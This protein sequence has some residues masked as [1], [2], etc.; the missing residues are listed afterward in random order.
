MV[1]GLA[2]PTPNRA[3]CHS[4]DCCPEP[5]RLVTNVAWQAGYLDRLVLLRRL[6]CGEIDRRIPFPQRTQSIG[7]KLLMAYGQAD[8]GSTVIPRHPPGS[9]SGARPGAPV[10]VLDCAAGDYFNSTVAPASVS[11]A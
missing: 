9:A 6:E 7:A 2:P 1:A 3:G 4:Q 5:L 10:E 8:T 11:F